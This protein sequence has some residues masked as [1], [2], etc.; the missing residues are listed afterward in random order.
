MNSNH[1]TLQMISILTPTKKMIRT[2][3]I[4]IMQY[5]L[6]ERCEKKMLFNMNFINV[7]KLSQTSVL[8]LRYSIK[9]R[10]SNLTFP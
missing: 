3:D 8:T 6:R 4:S 5:E 1:K 2:E 10:Y 9:T 7:L